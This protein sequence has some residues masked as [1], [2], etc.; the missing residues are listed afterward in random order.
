MKSMPGWM[1]GAACLVLI[2]MVTIII[3]VTYMKMKT[4]KKGTMNYYT[5]P[6][7]GEGE[8]EERGREG[9]RGRKRP[10]YED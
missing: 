8:G 4:P 3:I 7:E 1:T 6:P 5:V 10:D 2:T 9:E